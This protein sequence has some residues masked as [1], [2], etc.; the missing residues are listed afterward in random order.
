M[1]R[2]SIILVMIQ[3]LMFNSAVFAEGDEKSGTQ[4][5]DHAM[6][7]IGS[8]IMLIGIPVGALIGAGIGYAVAPSCPDSACNGSNMPE[9]YIPQNNYVTAYS[10]DSSYRGRQQGTKFI[11]PLI[12]YNF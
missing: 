5:N 3:C 11:L 4:D 8:L 6:S 7:S 10:P 2:L 9:K 1:F 12:S